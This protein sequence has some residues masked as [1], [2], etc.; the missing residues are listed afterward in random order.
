[1][2]LVKT[3]LL[4]AILSLVPIA[5]GAQSISGS[6]STAS[7]KGFTP[8]SGLSTVVIG[9]KIYAVGGDTVEYSPSTGNVAV[10]TGH[11]EVFDPLL[12]SW[13]TPASIG[14]FFDSASNEPAACVVDG[15]IFTIEYRSDTAPG[16]WHPVIHMYDPT[17]NSW[18]VVQS[19]GESHWRILSTLNVVGSKIYVVGGF[20]D[21]GMV[22]SVDVFDPATNSWSSPTLSGAMSARGE[23]ASAVVNNKIYVVGGGVTDSVDVFDPSI[24][25]WSI[26]KTTGTFTNR[27]ALSACVLNGKIFAIGGLYRTAT[28]VIYLN[29]VEVF[30]PNTNSWSTPTTTG[31]LTPRRFL[32]TAVVNGKIYVMG[33]ENG[34]G[35]VITVLNTNEV[36][37]PSTSGVANQQPM[38]ELEVSPN[39][40][41]GRVF[42][43]GGAGVTSTTVFNLLGEKLFDVEAIDRENGTI[44]LSRLSPGTYYLRIGTVD[45]MKTKVVVRE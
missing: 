12:N 28:E 40:T 31:T 20:N 38:G 29:I 39:P 19:T 44:D 37:T 26:L 2:T 21:S 7:S 8:R 25:S 30:D 45:G 6:W 14:S 4:V 17:K 22:Y 13:S 1:M 18:V 36:F 16:Q 34:D 32:S 41:T 23:F 3:A 42:V 33:G 43:S 11:F 10:A 27:T 35:V 5:V 9:G 24:N 15:K